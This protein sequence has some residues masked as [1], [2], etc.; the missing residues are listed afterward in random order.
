[1]RL[2]CRSVFLV[3]SFLQFGQNLYI[4]ITIHSEESFNRYGNYSVPGMT[5]ELQIRES[6]EDNSEVI[7][8]FFNENICCDPSRF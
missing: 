2:M 8:L 6:I 4:Y 3:Q 7:F 5:P 1:M